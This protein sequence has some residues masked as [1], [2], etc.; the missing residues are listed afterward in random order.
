[1]EKKKQEEA[2][3]KAKLLRE[4]S[5]NR[6]RSESMDMSLPGTVS[7]SNRKAIIRTSKALAGTALQR[8][9]RVKIAGTIY[10]IPED[11][12]FQ[13]E[14]TTITLDRPYEG[15]TKDG[16]VIFKVVEMEVG[17]ATPGF[18]KGTLSW[19]QH[20]KKKNEELS[21]TE[22]FFGYTMTWGEIIPL[23][24]RCDLSKTKEQYWDEIP[25]TYATKETC[26][27]RDRGQRL[28]L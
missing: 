2:M 26:G 15:E 27:F 21:R 28:W 13:F 3:A 9:D 5:R 1:M 11:E 25:E 16:L 14:N 17:E 7:V 6:L 4:K 8:G 18:M 22:S 24:G 12:K 10:T 23:L 19:A 20:E